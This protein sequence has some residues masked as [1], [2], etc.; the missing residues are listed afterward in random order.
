M[1][2][3]W[4]MQAQ[5]K[6]KPAVPDSEPWTVSALADRVSG[7]LK[8]GLPRV[9]RL[10]GEIGQWNRAASGHR[11]FTLK[12]ADSS[13]DAKMWKRAAGMLA[14]EPS[15]G[16]EVVAEGRCDFWGVRG[17]LS[18]VVDRL[19]PVGEGALDLAFRQLVE[20]LRGEGLFEAG[21]KRPVPP[22]PRTLAIVT[23]IQAA[24]FQDV[25]K[26]LRPFGHLR[27]LLV[28]VPVQ[29]DG[30][31]T[32]IANALDTLGARHGDVGG[33]DAVLLV[34]G[35][36]SRQDLW[37]FNEE[38]VARA[39]I[40]CGLPVVT[41]I[42]HETDQSVAD[43]VADLH[44]HT[45]T[46]A[47]QAIVRA[48][49]L[50]PDRIDQLGVVL[51]RGQR[52]RMESLAQQL[53]HAGRHELFRRP[54]EPIDRRRQ[55]VDELQNDLASALRRA[56]GRSSRRVADVRALLASHGPT[57]RIRLL[58]QQAASTFDAARRVAAA[59]LASKRGRL[60]ELSRRLASVDPARRAAGDRDRLQTAAH[61][62]EH[63]VQRSTHLRSRVARLAFDRFARLDPT[64]ALHDGRG[65]L[66]LSAERLALL[67][68][69][70]LRQRRDRLAT[71]D[72]ALR[73]LSPTAVL[74]RGYTITR[75]RRGDALLRSPADV[76]PGDVL[77]TL[78]P[79]GPVTSTVGTSEQDTLFS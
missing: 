75:R 28:N 7:A 79:D 48:W 4:D 62:F 77:D 9:I 69:T 18:F 51:R 68:R 5:L 22:Y 39:I 11:Y 38:V 59:S 42:G 55:R 56:A 61:R 12:D 33:I 53:R 49:R 57:P 36:G 54:T 73:T 2:S 74:G 37:A 1:P 17:Q 64:L 14:F 21:R 20:K 29:G 65:S 3:I 58:R 6:G 45:P 41:G 32:H 72:A 78:T 34:R 70:R 23:S 60:A 10:R 67:A 63:A 8:A 30:A 50:A 52:R 76:R 19:D 43:L 26:V 27:R 71:S 31:A 25:L 13:I 46:E 35:G 44:C 15:V 40:A 47:A 16:Q 66:E 24:G